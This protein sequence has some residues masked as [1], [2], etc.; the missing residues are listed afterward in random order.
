MSLIPYIKPTRYVHSS[1][2][3]TFEV[4]YLD[5]A[6]KKKYVIT[7]GSDHVYTDTRSLYD[8]SKSFGVNMDLTK[9][10]YIRIWSTGRNSIKWEDEGMGLSDMDLALG[11]PTITPNME[12]VEL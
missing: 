6:N 2:F 7:T 11:E 1:G 12:V 10:G 8:S 5:E 3:R 9:S 4:G